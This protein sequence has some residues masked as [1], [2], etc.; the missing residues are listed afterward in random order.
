MQKYTNRDFLVTSKE[1]M[2]ERDIEQLDFILISG[3]AYV[4]HPSFANAII[5]RTLESYGYSVGIIAQPNVDRVSSF[6]ILGSPRL[7]FLVSS[8]NIDSMVNHYTAA[9]KRR[10]DDSY[11]PGNIS[12]K[13]PDRA[14]IVYS[15]LIR[16]AYKGIPIIL[17]GVEASLRRFAHYDYWDNKVR[18]S[19]LADSTADLLV[20]GMGEATIKQI[21]DQLNSGV[22]ISDI[23]DI[24]GT[25]YISNKLPDGASQIPSFK[26]VANDKIDYAKAFKVQYENQDPITGKTLAQFTDKYYLVQNPPQMPLNTEELDYTY[27]LPFTRQIHPMY[28]EYV[29]AIEEVKFSV[30]HNRGCF[31]SCAFCALTFHQGR[32]VT[33]RSK[34]SVIDEV[35]KI[36]NLDDF[37]GYIH[38]IGGPTANFREPAC[39]KQ[40]KSGACKNKSCLGHKACP[41]LKVSHKEFLDILTEAN[42]VRGVKKVFVRS[43]IRFDYLLMEEDDTVLTELIKH[44]ISGQLKIAPEHIG[45][46]TLKLMG[47]PP[48]EIYEK[49]RKKYER[50]NAQLGMKQYIVPYFM[51]SHP[52]CTTKDA[53]A[54]ACYLKEHNLRP[55]QV[56]DFYPTPGTLSTTMF[57]TGINPLTNQ[58]VYIPKSPND[59]KVQRA[60]MQYFIPENKEIIKK[61]LLEN[62]RSDLIGS[63]PKCLIYEKQKS[64]YKQKNSTSNQRSSSKQTGHSRQNRTNSSKRN[65]GAKGDPLASRRRKSK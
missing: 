16:Q 29:P 58:K 52:G 38:D 23:T 26:E 10:T 65:F 59:K 61:V 44:H 18:R 36:A 47:K 54:L 2:Q 40:L 62:G 60:L 41:N 37:K 51:S 19:V 24:K 35:K 32:V 57:Y 4:D 1:D 21:A 14:V 30:A 50:I 43:G 5:G 13:R 49:F 9:K 28:K 53:I 48:K 56:Q 6:K 20:Y 63:D 12:G 27:S 33:S 25:C 22:H 11:T 3:D 42:K 46:S 39:E 7:A 34:S 17:G 31:G 55:R 45:D 15:N 64:N 8:G